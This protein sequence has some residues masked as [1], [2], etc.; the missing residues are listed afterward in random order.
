[1]AGDSDSNETPEL[2]P[3]I[4]VGRSGRAHEN[5]QPGVS[6]AAVSVRGEVAMPN[7]VSEAGQRNARD[8]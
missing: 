7:L 1:V 6:E 5:F 8:V 4:E 2:L 3:K